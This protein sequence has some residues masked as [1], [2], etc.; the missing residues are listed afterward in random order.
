VLQVSKALKT[1]A[2][3]TSLAREK[4]EGNHTLHPG[5]FKVVKT[6]RVVSLKRAKAAEFPTYRIYL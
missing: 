6:T 1:L 5:G 2:K 3:L 4:M